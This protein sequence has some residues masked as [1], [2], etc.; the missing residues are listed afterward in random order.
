MKNIKSWLMMFITISALAQNNTAIEPNNL[1]LSY[2]KTTSIVFPYSVK[3]V[4]RGSQDVL[5]QKAKGVENILLLKAG[6]VNFKQTNLTVVTSDGK[7]YA[8]ILNFDEQ[9]PTLNLVAEVSNYDTDV[10]FF[11]ENENQKKIEQFSQLALSKKK[12]ITGLKANQFS[13]QLQ[14]N[15]IFIHH[16]VMYFRVVV[17]NNSRISYDIDQ[18]R[19]FIRDQ[20]KTKRAASQEIEI[21]PLF[22]KSDFTKIQDY[23]E[24]TL[25]FA[26]PKF[27]IP[28]KK[29]FTLQLIE[30][31]GGRHVELD[32]KNKDLIN[33]EILRSL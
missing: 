5:V 31:N 22:A 7:L 19:F 13:V 4:D 25:V 29:L 20:K 16:D 3:S 11:T 8:F 23:S 1:Q 6:I 21:M 18:L 15:G 28:E 2:S 26:V 33:L 32:I 14:V 10:L 9:C 30:K 27:T 17:V 12:K 24:V